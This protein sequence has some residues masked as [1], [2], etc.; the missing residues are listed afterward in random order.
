MKIL[1]MSVRDDEKEAITEWEK[2]NNIEV[3]TVDWE[4]RLD[5]VEELV[6]Y[7][8][9]VIQQRSKVEK[10][11]YP[12]LKAIGIKQIT[13]RTA[14]YDVVDIDLAREN[15]LVITNVP[16]YSP[17]SVAELALAHT[18]RLIRKLEIFDERMARQDFRWAGLQATEIHSLTVGIIGAGR[19]GGTTAKIFDAL[20]AKV[21]AYDLVERDE[22][23]S[24][25]DYMSKE[26]VLRNADVIC[27]HVDLNQTTVD[28]M[29]AKE[30][31]LMKP[32]AYLINECRGPVVETDALI[33][34]LEEKKIAGAAL[35]TLTG[36]ENFFNFDLQN[37]DLPSTQ[38]KKLRAM[39]NVILTPHVGFFTNIAVQNMVDISLNDVV[40]ILNGKTSEHQVS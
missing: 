35:D 11:V 32:T 25:V 15:N 8:G 4:L 26:E 7:D 31:E 24:I 34:A 18:M 21:I 28:L 1:M 6:G 19:I 12:A 33:A 40:L 3:K 37:K 5:K 13:L 38:L 20:G 17:R 23:K 29:G 14:G 10:A 9:I 39:D 27:L 2:R 16:A 22:L 30:F 36:E